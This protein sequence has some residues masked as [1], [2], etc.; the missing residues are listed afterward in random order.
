MISGSGA[1]NASSN[2]VINNRISGNTT[3]V[4]IS[5]SGALNA[6]LNTVINNLI[7]GNTTGVVISG[8]GASNASS[9]TVINN[10]ISGNTTGV[11]ISGSGASNASSNAVIN[12]TISS[13]SEAGVSISGSGA[14]G[15]LI[16]GNSVQGTFSRSN[17]STSSEPVGIYVDSSSN[18]IGGTLPSDS[19]VI[20][21]NQVGILLDNVNGSSG[22]SNTV[23]NNKINAEG[24]KMGNFI[25]VWVNGAAN[26]TIGM[27]GAGN[28]ILSN[29]TMEAGIY[30]FKSGATGTLI[31]GNTIIGGQ[32]TSSTIFPETVGVYIQDSSSNTIGG[33]V[34][35]EGNTISGN[36][37]GV[38]VFST[39]G[40]SSNNSVLRNQIISPSSGAAYGTLL[41]NAPNNNVPLS[42]SLANTYSGKYLIDTFLS[43]PGRR[44]GPTVQ[45]HPVKG[46]RSAAKKPPQHST[47]V[48][49][50]S[51]RRAAS[52]ARVTV[53]GRSV[54]VGPMRN[55]RAGVRH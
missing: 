45:S 19:N 5:G 43:L 27:P 50:P 3:G 1:S 46:S 36:N 18:T 52:L 21:G 7:S 6:S 32:T 41:Y 55:T 37:V 8:S 14:T 22:S 2:T 42:R 38:Y 12:N 11:V 17:D 25:G 30:I 40:L 23:E 15:T 47:H 33:T 9:N 31:Q 48:V 29:G 44:V 39:G 51:P 26:N 34:Q 49:K 28:T 24:E 54:P 10:L 20:S 4:M 16:Q 13:Y 53:H 35:G